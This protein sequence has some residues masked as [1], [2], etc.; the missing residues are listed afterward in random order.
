MKSNVFRILSL[1]I[2]LSLIVGS[3]AKN[4]HSGPQPGTWSLED[5]MLVVPDCDNPV[6]AD[7]IA[8]QH[9]CV[10][11]V[12]AERSGNTVT[13]TYRIEDPLWSISEIHLAVGEVPVTRKANPMVGKFGI[14][15]E[16]DEPVKSKTFEMEVF[17]DGPVIPIAA[18]AV[19][20]K[21]LALEY[22]NESL[23]DGQVEYEV[24]HPGE[25]SYFGTT[26]IS[27]GETQTYS[28]WC[29][30]TDHGIYSNTPYKAELVSTYELAGMGLVEYPE[31]L[32][33]VNWIIN[34][35]FLGQVSVCGGEFTYGDIQ[36]AIWALIDDDQS[37]SGLGP[38]EQCRVDE[39]LAKAMESGTAFEP[40]CE[41][42]IAVAL[43]PYDVNGQPIPNQITITQITII[44]QI[45]DCTEEFM[46]ET[47]WGSGVRF[48]EKNWATLFY[49]CN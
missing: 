30:D 22:F 15:E 9:T 5:I 46:E 39:I 29:I 28:G 32:D 43:V 25:S 27:N 3:C 2:G 44:E 35:D 33:K 31:N 40:D 13:V 23:P 24:V 26:I 8:G 14:N 49:I 37:T 10:G 4:E 38:W 41:Q 21:N 7:L 6:S 17:I 11:Y 45:I 18:H 20:R 12:S 47:A 42:E 34:Q 16:Y 19:V 36:R 48:N 1:A